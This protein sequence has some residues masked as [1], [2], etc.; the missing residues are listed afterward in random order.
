MLPTA[1]IA[2]LISVEKCSVHIQWMVKN[3]VATDGKILDWYYTWSKSDLKMSTIEGG[4][5]YAA[6]AHLDRTSKYGSLHRFSDRFSYMG[7]WSGPVPILL[8]KC[9]STSC[10]EW[11]SAV[12]WFVSNVQIYTP[13]LQYTQ[14]DSTLQRQVRGALE[15]TAQ[16]KN[17][18]I[19]HLGELDLLF[20]LGHDV[21]SRQ[22]TDDSF[23]T[24]NLWVFRRPTWR[25]KRLKDLIVW[26]WYQTRCLQNYAWTYLNI[27]A[28]WSSEPYAPSADMSY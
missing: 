26:H 18:L 8:K 4:L 23:W 19:L 25:R 28:K 16:L 27:A 20:T 10:Y 6:K 9:Y 2:I 21:S 1:S 17:P 22:T 5:Y 11:L 13:V 3:F 15:R 7:T 24:Q 14:A 12:S